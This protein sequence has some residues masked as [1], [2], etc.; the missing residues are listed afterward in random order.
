MRISSGYHSRVSS[1]SSLGF[2]PGVLF[3]TGLYALA[4]SD[5]FTIGMKL[6]RATSVLVL[7]IMCWSRSDRHASYERLILLTFLSNDF[8]MYG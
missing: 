3:S 2:V 1:L 5:A 4:Q 7:T 6:S 8:Q